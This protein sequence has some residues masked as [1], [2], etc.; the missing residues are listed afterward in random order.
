VSQCLN[1]TR[2][3]DVLFATDMLRNN[4]GQISITR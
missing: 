2:S 4:K 1:F 3:V